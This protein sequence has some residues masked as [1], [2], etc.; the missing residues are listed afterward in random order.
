MRLEALIEENYDKLNENDLS[1]WNFIL[2]NKKEQPGGSTNEN[3]KHNVPE[4]IRIF[5]IRMA[6][7]FAV[8]AG[9]IFV[10]LMISLRRYIIL[11]RQ[12]KYG[13][14]QI[15]V[16]MLEVLGMTGEIKDCLR[17]MI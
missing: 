6:P 7:V 16:R 9:I 12:E 4:R 10:W 17:R 5:F 3:R 11:R 15:M 2:R 8:A 13:A 1:I 14:G